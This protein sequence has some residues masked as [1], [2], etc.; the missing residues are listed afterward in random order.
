MVPG[1]AHEIAELR[2]RIV[3]LRDEGRTFT[4]IGNIVGRD[5]STVWHHYQ[6]AM[7]DIPAT[8]V[9]EHQKKLASR[10]DEQLARI[11]MERERLME[12]L[13]KSHVHI[14]NGRVVREI[15]GR[16]KD[17]KPIL[18]E[19][20]E[21]DGPTMAA[22]DRLGRLDDQEAKLLGLYPKQT[23]VLERPTSELDTAVIALIQ[24]AKATAAEKRAAA[25]ARREVAP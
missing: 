2:R 3:E 21:D 11:D 12:I 18:G 15:I 23:M 17:G 8:A 25:L 19:P 16:E 14:S 5:T 4:D 10:L 22:I 13:G 9:E 24:Q 7:R 1:R 6:R 20:F